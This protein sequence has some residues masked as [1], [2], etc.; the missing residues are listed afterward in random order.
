[1]A[2]QGMQPVLSAAAQREADRLTIGEFGLP[3]TLLMETAGRAVASHIVAKLSP[4]AGRHVAVVAGKGN[5]GGDGYVVARVLHA[6]GAHVS[7]WEPKGAEGLR[8]DAAFHRQLLPKIADDRLHIKPLDGVRTSQAD[9]YVDALLGSG[10]SR[11]LRSNL[12]R[13]VRFLN[14]QPA[15][16]VAVDIPTGLHA[17]SGL[18]LGYAIRADATVTM[19]SPSPG[20]FLG[21]GPKYTGDV[22]VAD[23]GIPS[24]TVARVQR[25]FGPVWR[26]SDA[27]IGALLPRR[28]HDAHKYDAGMALVVAGSSGLTGA[29][30]MASRAAARVGAGYVMCATHISGQPV[31]ATK[32]TSV[33]SMGLPG[34]A[35][36]ELAAPQALEALRGMLRRARAVLVGP[37]LGRSEGTQEFV[38]ML[39]QEMSLPAVVDAD[40]LGSWVGREQE[41]RRHSAGRWILTPHAGEF[42][43][44]TGSAD[45]SDRIQAARHWAGR[46]D[47]VLVAKGMPS[48]VATPSG[49]VYICSSGSR[50]LA[51]AGTGDILAG[52]C[53]G[54]LAQGLAPEEAAVTAVH[55]G[56]R[57]AEHYTRMNDPESMV[58]TDMLTVLPGVLRE[59]RP[60]RSRVR[61]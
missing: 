37:G 57:C 13:V 16:V 43:R 6:Q 28:A 25:A 50:A 45:Q 30:V 2:L 56:G 3:G 14:A 18:V 11:P 39:L 9:V 10:L 31:I 8:G 47:V 58:A 24:R 1:M 44:L 17:D 46:W 40:G 41:I 48:L 5:N 53:A 23:I 29:A 4:I 7:V 60:L 12:A 22:V 32:L 26:T 51:T 21:E 38:R 34:R 42:S 54:L 15:P 61:W 52:L 55:L 33:A 27:A 36:G 35:P 59:L 19:G 49:H 20:L